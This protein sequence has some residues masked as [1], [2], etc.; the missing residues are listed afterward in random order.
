V[1]P[2]S[3]LSIK[4]KLTLI[5]TVPTLALL[6]ASTAILAYAYVSVR[7]AEI[8]NL[9]T[10]ADLISAR[11]PALLSLGDE[12]AARATMAALAVN[13]NVTRSYIFSAAGRMF[14]GYLH[15]GVADSP[16]PQPSERDGRI[17]TWDRIGVFRP[18]MVGSK[19]IST[20]Y[21]ESDRADQ[22]ARLRRAVFIVVVVL[23][24]SLFIGLAVSSALHQ[25]VSVPILRLSETARLVSTE[26][27]YAI[28]VEPGKADEVGT[29]IASFNVM[30]EQIQSRDEMLRGHQDHLEREVAA[31]TFQ[32]TTPNRELL[33]PKDRAEEGSPAK[34][35]F[36]ANMSHETRTPMNGIIGMTDL[37]LD[38]SL[39]T[40][41]REQLGLVRTSAESLLLIV[42]DILDFSKID[43]GRMDLDPTEFTL[44]DTLDDVIAG[45]AVRAHE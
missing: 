44:R 4:R 33:A 43:A 38:T 40:E 41:Q 14:A 17:V 3:E 23:V 35:E 6:L 27:N 10:V 32:L 42:N 22:H 8:G 11:S 45:L 9:E 16:A 21:V 31:R 24:G 26:K 7:N 34:T 28:R 13:T 39:S 37:T 12:S 30:L 29:L 1:N 20:T 5:S 36:L 25:I 15:P 18:L 19:M 2:F